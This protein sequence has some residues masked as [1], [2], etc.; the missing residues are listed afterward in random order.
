MN[1]VRIPPCS[2]IPFAAAA[3]VRLEEIAGVEDVAMLGLAR[4]GLMLVGEDMLITRSFRG[5]GLVDPPHRHDDHESIG[6]LLSGRLRL[7]IDGREFVAGPGDSWVHRR[8][9]VH[10][11][12]ALE[13]CEQVEIKSPPRRTWRTA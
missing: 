9:V 1:P 5:K 10:A 11:S 8:G 4:I 7:V 12:E 6:F 3:D 2:E 13:D